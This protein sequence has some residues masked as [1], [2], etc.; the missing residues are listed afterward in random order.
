MQRGA[1]MRTRE[2]S[3]PQLAIDLSRLHGWKLGKK[4]RLDLTRRRWWKRVIT[5]RVG[6]N[7]A[8]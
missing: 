4:V 7:T 2:A 3:Y 1:P 8:F 6:Q 5:R